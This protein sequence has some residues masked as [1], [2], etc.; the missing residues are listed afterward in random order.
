[1]SQSTSEFI[2]EIIELKEDAL[3]IFD[4]L[5]SNLDQEAASVV[6]HLMKLQHSEIMALKIALEQLQ[7]GMDDHVIH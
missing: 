6:R 7:A 3:A 4:S 1:M 5:A 2:A